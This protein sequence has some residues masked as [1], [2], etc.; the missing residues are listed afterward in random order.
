MISHSPQKRKVYRFLWLF[1]VLTSGLM[2]TDKVALTMKTTGD[3]RHKGLQVPDFQSLARGTSLF[4]GD[5]VLT[6]EDG[7][8]V[9]LFLDDKSVVSG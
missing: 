8:A 9:A 6:G 3:V 7:L 5:F 1:L 4:D 2:A